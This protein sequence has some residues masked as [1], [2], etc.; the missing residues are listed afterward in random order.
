MSIAVQLLGHRR[1]LWWRWPT[2]LAILWIFAT[3]VSRLSAQG[4]GKENNP[5]AIRSVD[6]SGRTVWPIQKAIAA[7]LNWLTRHQSKDGNWSLQE[8]TK[9]CSDATCTGP[10]RDESLC[11]ATAMGVLPLLAAG[12]SPTHDGPFKKTVV[13]GLDWLVKHQ[14]EGGDL[15]AGAKQQMYSHGLA[16]IVLCE[17]YGQSKDDA[18]AKSAQRAI[19]FIEDAQS[20]QTGGWRYYPGEEGDTS[21]F[22]WQIAALT[23]A[24]RA[25]LKVNPAT[26]ESAKRLLKSVTKTT[27]VGVATG[28]FSYMPDSPETPAIS[29]VGILCSQ[30]L[31]VRKEDP[32]IANGVKYLMKNKPDEN[33][34]N[35]YY[36]LY[37]TQVLHNVSGKDWDAWNR[38]VRKILVESQEHDGCA[39]GSWDPDKPTRD[40]W[41]PT[42]GRLMATSFA[43]LTLEVHYR[44]LLIF[45]NE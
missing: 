12:Q 45:K 41:S 20:Q 33:K 40:A 7:G 39:A 14:A 3:V 15:A 17:A 1:W 38:Q 16:A 30:R 42:G 8:Y 31:G 23:S 28:K 18:L 13:S 2:P 4:P 26:I 37:G 5:A 32:L 22:G 10:G 6:R 35:L 11:A 21:V 44:Y 24:Q 43:C 29:A 25:G 9:Q 19:D 34:R 36:W 27:D